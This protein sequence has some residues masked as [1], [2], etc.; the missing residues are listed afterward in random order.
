MFMWWKT[1][2]SQGC[3]NGKEGGRQLKILQTS[4]KYG[5][6]EAAGRCHDASTAAL[7]GRGAGRGRGVSDDD[8][9]GDRH[10]GRR[11]T[12][13]GAIFVRRPIHR[14]GAMFPNSFIF[15]D[16]GDIK[17]VFKKSANV[18]QVSPSRRR[19]L[20]KTATNSKSSRMKP[21]RISPQRSLMG[22]QQ[23]LQFRRRRPRSCLCARRRRR[24]RQRR[25]KRA[26]PKTRKARGSQ[27]GQYRFTREAASTF[28]RI[29]A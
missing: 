5:P 21:V 1:E 27:S 24:T 22:P 14:Y 23:V 7:R 11:G 15:M 12:L 29:I 28:D 6:N 26:R 8:G 25:T 18:K 10:E 19:H 13:Q 16:N 9:E 3:G 17:I 4:Y 2:M 20:A